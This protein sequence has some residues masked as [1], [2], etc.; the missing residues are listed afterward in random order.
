MERIQRSLFALI[1]DIAEETYAKGSSMA[2]ERLMERLEGG[3]WFFPGSRE[4][5]ARQLVSAALHEAEFLRY[6][7]MHRNTYVDAPVCLDDDLSLKSRPGVYLA[8]QITGVEGYVE[9]AACGLWV[10][11]LLAAKLRGTT[12]PCLPPETALG[13]LIGHLRTPTKD[14]QPSN[15]NFGLMP[16]LGM[17]LKKKERKPFYAR[18]AQAAFAQWLQTAAAHCPLLGAD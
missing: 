5:V 12:L 14:F 10:G 7:S 11:L 18:R 2:A 8:G 13:A 17:R 15:V 6:G 16:E 9:S 3:G 1:A 4:V